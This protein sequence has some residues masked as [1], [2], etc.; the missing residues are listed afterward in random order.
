MKWPVHRLAC[1]MLRM[2][3]GKTSLGRTWRRWKIYIEI[4]LQGIEFEDVESIKM[5]KNISCFPTALKALINILSL[6]SR[7]FL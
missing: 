3:N 4:C 6:N 5:K 2:A 1:R 7:I